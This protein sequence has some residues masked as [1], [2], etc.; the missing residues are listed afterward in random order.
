[1]G[2]DKKSYDQAYA[3]EHFKRVP[4]D[5]PLSEYEAL[6]EHMEK[7]GETKVNAYLRRIISEEIKRGGSEA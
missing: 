7:I 5:M 3:K 6:R 2:F 1:M 4:L